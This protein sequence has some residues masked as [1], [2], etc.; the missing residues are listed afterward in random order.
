[1]ATLSLVRTTVRTTVCTAVIRVGVSRAGETFA[2]GSLV[3]GSA[4]F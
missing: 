1:M 4:V 3:S 2:A